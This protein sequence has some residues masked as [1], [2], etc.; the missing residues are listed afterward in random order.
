MIISVDKASNYIAFKC[1]KSYISIKW[2]AEGGIRRVRV[3]VMMFM[4]SWWILSIRSLWMKNVRSL[5][6][7]MDQSQEIKL[8]K[9]LST[10][11]ASPFE[12]L[13][14]AIKGEYKQGNNLFISLGI[15]Q[16]LREIISIS[17][18]NYEEIYIFFVA[19]N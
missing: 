14:E 2:R 15:S 16:R 5:S 19:Q 3:R 10:L 11:M 6:I 17:S 7:Y 12:P 4:L 13:K 8:N 1:E 18:K 9:V